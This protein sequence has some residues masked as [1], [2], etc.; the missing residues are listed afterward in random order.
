MSM[1]AQS[2]RPLLRALVRAA[3]LGGLLQAGAASALTLMQAYQAAL[4]N[5]PTYQ[6]AVQDAAAG[7]EYRNIGRS[8]LLPNLSAS[9]SASQNRSDLRGEGCW[10]A[11]R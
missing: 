9:Y 5:D 10:A 8:A 4:L 3:V 1:Q 2:R 11:P 6:G 7:E